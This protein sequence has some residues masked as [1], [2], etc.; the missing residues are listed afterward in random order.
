[1]TDG[2]PATI[3]TQSLP[4]GLK[5]RGIGFTVTF[6]AV[7]LVGASASFTLVSASPQLSLTGSSSGIP[8]LVDLS[9]N[10]T[11]IPGP[12]PAFWGVS[13]D[14]GNPNPDTASLKGFLNAT[15]FT[16][17]RYGATWVDEENWSSGCFYNG[18]SICS[19]LHNNVSDY[20][21]LCLSSPRYYCILG[22]PAEINSES[23]LAYEVNWL[24]STTGWQPNC[25]AVG[26]EP[27]VWTHFGIPW[28]SWTSKDTRAATPAQFALV[29]ANYTNTL[30]SLD[31]PNTCVIGLESN[32]PLPNIGPWTNAVTAAVTNDTAVAFHQYPDAKCT[33][34]GK[35][36]TT[37]PLAQLLSAANLTLT[38]AAYNESVANARGLPVYIQEFNMGS[39][40]PPTSCSPWVSG[41]TDSVFTSAVVAQALTYGDPQLTYFHFDCTTPDCLVNE[42]TSTPSPTY[43]LYEDLLSQMDLEQIHR[44]NITSGGNPQI[45]AVLGQNGT[46]DRT[47]LLSN[48]QPTASLELNESSFVP[49][50]PSDWKIQTVSENWANGVTT[51]AISTAPTTLLVQ[52]QTT[53]LVHYWNSL[54]FSANVTFTETG[55][56]IG[57]TW[58]MHISGQGSFGTTVTSSGG[59]S[60]TIELPDGSYS[61][62]AESSNSSWAPPPSYPS[63]FVDGTPLSLGIAFTLV[64]YPVQFT[65][66]GLP[67]GQNWSV[68]FNGV[69][70]N[71]TT[72]DQPDPLMFAAE[73]NGTYAYSIMDISGFHQNTIPYRGTEVVDGAGIAESVSFSQVL[74]NVTFSESGLPSGLLWNVTL[75]GT[76]LSLSTGGLA[77]SL[78]FTEPNGT[79]SYSV[80]DNP[81]WHQTTLDYNGIVGVSGSSVGEVPLVYTP[82]TYPVVFS[83]S[84]LPSGLTFE[85]TVAGVAQYL[86]T[87]GGADAL[88]FTEL[89]GSIAYSIADISGWH[90]TSL[91]YNGII[92]VNG[93]PLSESLTYVQVTYGVTF[94]ETGL[95]SGSAWTVTFNGVLMS[96]TTDGAVGTL[97][98]AAEPNG[99][100]SYSIGGASGFHQGSV[101]Y[102]GTETVGGGALVVSMTYTQVTY[103]VTFS[104]SGLP[105]DLTWSVTVNGALS[106]LTTDGGTDSLI[107]T[108]PNGTYPYSISTLSGWSQSVLPYEG[109]VVVP[110]AAVSEPSAI[111]TE[112]TYAVTFQEKGLPV[113]TSWWVSILGDPLTASAPAIPTRE[114]N[115]TFSYAVWSIAGYAPAHSSG[116]VT[117]KAAALKVTVTFAPVTYAVTFVEAGLPAGTGWSVTAGGTTLAS[118]A[119]HIKFQLTNGT[120]RYSI[121]PI[122]GYHIT[123]GSYTGLVT[124]LGAGLTAATVHWTLVKYVVT[125]TKTGLPKGTTWSVTLDGQTKSVTG[126]SISFNV[127]NGTYAF[128]IG[129]TGYSETSSPPGPL[130]V[131]GAAL[132]VAV[133]FVA[134]S[135]SEGG[136]TTQGNLVSAPRPGG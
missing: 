103:G 75:N 74:Y 97:A 53:V 61:F 83:E 99:T 23:T 11:A 60:R 116:S 128:K 43:R 126:S 72:S 120:Y 10:N 67:N 14:G 112:V 21:E 110:A 71:G 45:F 115:G 88:F 127:P 33:D 58:N 89:N 131:N 17:L 44:V 1:M 70:L 81:G 31:G 96:L 95:P 134:G 135:G 123:T 37:A 65:K 28:T 27:E 18:N 55:L 64:T 106:S 46:H 80:G 111:Y 56:P 133:T 25:W 132:S 66:T 78:A 59:T 26:N 117:V 69:T 107:F 32:G 52:N 35:V 102:A 29:A 41:Y 124:I 82:V 40:S 48:A 15:P 22:V 49:S 129:A 114:P 62:S 2:R 57:T 5:G 39:A 54:P 13:L 87:N 130:V 118:T 12:G 3:H 105:S 122:A 101:P 4:R 108:E 19:P 84:T 9:V 51:S 91:P 109:S 8:N 34:D 16:V 113:G 79:F 93:G 92:A 47:L 77:N 125:F 50:T 68:T 94:S 6:F 98:F 90:Q 100:Y 76:T 121:E 20:A 63:L 38:Q 30:R 73:P 85:V 136:A 104:E 24:R 42:T 119:S 7:I 36:G 86:T